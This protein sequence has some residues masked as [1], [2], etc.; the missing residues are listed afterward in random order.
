MKSRP[1]VYHLV[2]VFT[3][4]PFGGNQ[5]AVFPEDGE[6]PEEWM[7]KIA[8]ELNLSETTFVTTPQEPGADFRVRI[9]TPTRE[10]PMAGHP[11]VGT[12]YVLTRLGKIASANPAR[13]VFEEGVGPIPMEICFQDGEPS[14][15]FMDQPRPNF[16]SA[17]EDRGAIADMLSLDL[18]DITPGLPLQAVSCGLPFLLVPLRRLEAVQKIKLKNDRLEALLG[19]FAAPNVL[20][21]SLETQHPQSTVHC[22]VFA[23]LYGVQEDPATGSANGPLGAYLVHH[24]L[25]EKE[26]VV[27]IRSEQG[28]EMG[29]PS[30]LDIEIYTQGNK[31]DRVRIGGTC[32][33]MGSGKLTPP[34]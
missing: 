10:I 18:E 22:R 31:I 14:A 29:R 20:A 13:V 24:R 17:F 16:G 3:D 12:A 26:G 11:S 1:L 34:T 28:M 15:I 33:Y 7:Q 32:V 6:V 23:P 27:H 21:F 25:V 8:R 2:D 4:Q 5:L 19:E 30:F 9:F